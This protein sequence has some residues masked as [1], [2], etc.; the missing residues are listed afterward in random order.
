[1][2]WQFP[3]TSWSQVI[4][5]RDGHSTESRQAL[6]SL[7]RA[8]WYPLYAFVRLQGHDPEASRDLTQAY[9]VELLEK[10]YLQ[11]VDPSLGRFRSFLMVS[12]KHF[13]SKE[14]DKAKTVKRGGATSVISFDA[15]DAEVRYRSEPSVELTPEVIF[16]RR[17]AQTV[18]HRAL[19]KLRD[20]LSEAGKED[21]YRALRP[22]LVGEEP[23]M[24][25]RQAAEEL[26]ISE[27]AVRAHVHRLRKRFGELLR[28]EIAETIADPE[29]VDDELRHLLGA[30]TPFQ[31]GTV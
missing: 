16:E 21:H 30:I 31:K 4:A 26:G 7:C 28:Q 2:K 8:Y 25:Y 6:D 5:A 20:E 14:R 15:A 29:D 12:V 1:M 23:R 18:L 24:P 22:S 17:W 11:D 27:G 13:L 10:G 9:F 3:P 19:G